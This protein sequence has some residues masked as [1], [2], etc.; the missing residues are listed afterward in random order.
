MP[1]CWDES[2]GIGEN[3]PFGHVA[4]TL[5][6]TVSGECP[7]GYDK[8]IPEVQL[9]IRIN[10][11]NG[12][13]YQL[14][15]D[16]DLFHVDFMSGW[17]EGKLAEILEE[18]QPFGDLGY[19][20]PCGCDEFLT[21]SPSPAE[22][23]CDVDAREHILDEATD[24]VTL[25]PRASNS[26]LEIIP[27]TW[28]V[29]PPFDCKNPEVPCDDSTLNFRFRRRLISCQDVADRSSS[30]CKKAL[31]KSHCPQTCNNSSFCMKDSKARFQLN[32]NKKKLIKNCRWVKK[33]LERCQIYD[34]CNTCRESCLNFNQCQDAA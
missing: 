17:Q 20:P 1:T 3:D 5:D 28:T 32:N 29:D 13:T 15:N 4:Y 19:N 33:N 21:E 11:Y 30:L 23:V 10:N 6:G 7:D 2:K 25:L 8:R 27:K 14:S 12:G 9:F 16:S 34:M 24:V 18:C 22:P 26:D 31:I